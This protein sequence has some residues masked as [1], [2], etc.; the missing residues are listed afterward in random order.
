MR[1]TIAAPTA[2]LTGLIMAAGATAHD[3]SPLNAGTPIGAAGAGAVKIGMTLRQAEAATGQDFVP[4]G[5]GR[6]GSVCWTARV[7]GVRGLGFMFKG[8][9]VARV[10]TGYPPARN[11]TA[12]GIRM[13]DSEAEVKRAYRGR[14]SVERHL[15]DAGGHYLVYKP[16]QRALR[17]RRIIFETDGHRVTGIRAGRLPEVGFVEGCS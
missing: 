15:Y 1:M 14:I 10:D 12:A 13:G 6:P 3:A 7:K 2:V 5:D 17:N 16:K 8:S 11:P 4:I 9:R